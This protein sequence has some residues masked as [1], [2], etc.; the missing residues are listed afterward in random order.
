M[1]APLAY[2]LV[3][4]SE[5]RLAVPSP[6]MVC[7]YHLTAGHAGPSTHL[8]MLVSLGVPPEDLLEGGF[9]AVE[10]CNHLKYVVHTQGTPSF[11]PP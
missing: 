5:A 11:R 4:L 10:G 6:L 3:T 8:L 1:D 7:W 9:M 2:T